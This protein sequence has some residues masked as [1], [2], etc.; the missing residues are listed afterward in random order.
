MDDLGCYWHSPRQSMVTTPQRT[1]EKEENNVLSG[2]FST[3]QVKPL[4]ARKYPVFS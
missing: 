4:S 2:V 1:K 3:H